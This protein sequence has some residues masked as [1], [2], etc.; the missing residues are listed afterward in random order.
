[1]YARIGVS[2][3]NIRTHGLN[4][5]SYADD[6]QFYLAFQSHEL[7]RE[8]SRVVDVLKWMLSN[9]LKL[10]DNKTELLHIGS[11]HA[12]KKINFEKCSLKKG[13]S[14]I[15]C[16]N[17][18]KN[19]GDIFDKY[20]TMERFVNAKC[21]SALYS[22]RCISKVRKCLDLDT[23]KTLV[24]ALV[25]SKLDYS[26]SVLFGVN[27]G[28][29]R[30][31]QVVQN[32]AARVIIRVRR[33]EHVTPILHKLHWLPIP[34]RVKFK[35]LMICFKCMNNLAP[36]YLSDLLEP[37][38]PGRSLRNRQ[39][40]LTTKRSRSK[41]GDQCFSIF[42]PVLWNS[43]P[44]GIRSITN[45]NAFKKSLKTPFHRV[46]RFL[47]YLTTDVFNRQLCI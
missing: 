24:Q 9:F 16:S 10:N 17:S 32:S 19:L 35:V 36:K 4:T 42:A 18:A 21:Q 44:T 46:L 41:A 34:I 12:L 14:E 39:N 25:I 30:K 43:L 11:K 8:L 26:N 29:L 7:G 15:M 27:S 2:F 37:Y 31:L 20:M 6:A 3:V 45:V 40:T 23:T 47:N 13:Q 38:T 5:H 1:M 22:L 33:R 28:Y